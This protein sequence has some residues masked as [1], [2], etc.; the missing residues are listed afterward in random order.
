[1]TNWQSVKI[2]ENSWH[3]LKEKTTHSSLFHS[4][5]KLYLLEA[6][7][8]QRISLYFYRNAVKTWCSIIKHITLFQI[9]NTVKIVSRQ[10]AESA[11]LHR[12]T[13]SNSEHEIHQPLPFC[14]ETSCA[15]F[16]GIDVDKMWQQSINV[17]NYQRKKDR[18]LAINVPKLC[19]LSLCIEDSK[20]SKLLLDTTTVAVYACI[21]L[22]W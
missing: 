14:A 22:M 13:F 7:L 9:C 21:V 8:F 2:K 10:W 11:E 18:Q 16:G 1:M 17:W 19:N 3:I 12:P 5:S 15:T 4:G 6:I 20:Q